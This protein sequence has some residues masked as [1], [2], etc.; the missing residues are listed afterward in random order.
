[1]ERDL[2]VDLRGYQ[3][4]ALDWMVGREL[5]L[6]VF[7]FY[8]LFSFFSLFFLLF[9]LFYD[10]FYFFQKG[11]QFSAIGSNELH[12]LWKQLPVHPQHPKGHKKKKRER[13]KKRRK[14]KGTR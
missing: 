9:L 11:Q 10:L 7:L 6:E 14:R 12:L 4:A 1:M 3:K 13:E 5:L 8:F 2:K